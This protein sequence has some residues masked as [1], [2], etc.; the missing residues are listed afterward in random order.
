V[1]SA[2]ADCHLSQSIL[3]DTFISLLEPVNH[4]IISSAAMVTQFAVIHIKAYCHL[5]AI[6][7]LVCYAA[8]D[9]MD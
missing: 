7:N 3:K 2:S 9:H 8:M 5:R 6:D 4:D 1:D